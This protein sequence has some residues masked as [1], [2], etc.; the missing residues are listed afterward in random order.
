[1]PNHPHALVFRICGGRPLTPSVSPRPKLPVF[2]FELPC[3][4]I[5]IGSPLGSAPNTSSTGKGL[6]EADWPYDVLTGVVKKASCASETPE[7]TLAAAGLPSYRES[8]LRQYAAMRHSVG[9][10]KRTDLW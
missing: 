10:R 9:P 3:T 2:S 7:A 4:G 6:Q 5:S 8:A 1:M